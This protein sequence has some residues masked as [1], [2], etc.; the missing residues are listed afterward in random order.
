MKAPKLR[1]L[2][3]QTIVITGA[4]SGIGL[5]TARKAAAEGAKLVLA[6][7]NTEDLEELQ[8]E[9]G[10]STE[11]DHQVAVVTAD[12]SRRE[13]IQAI[14]NT[15]LTRF[16][17]IDTWINNAG[18]SI[19]GKLAEV[20]EEDSRRLFETNFWSV[21][22]GSL[23]AVKHMKEKGG[24]LINMG[25]VASDVAIPLQGMYSATKHAVKGFTD[26]LRYEL[27]KDQVPI[28]VTLIKPGGIDTPFPEHAKN[29]L[30]EQPRLP[31][32]VCVPD[33]VALAILTAA[34]RPIRDVYVGSIGPVL[35]TAQKFFP[36]LT[37]RYIEATMFKSQRRVGEPA[38]APEGSLEQPG[39]GLEERNQHPGH[40]M[41]KS[42][43]TRVKLQPW[44]RGAGYVATGV[45]ASGLILTKRRRS[46]EKQS[47]SPSEEGST[48]PDS[49]QETTS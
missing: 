47:F 18:V 39:H 11:T 30:E 31:S 41:K 48:H 29:Y 4:T 27:E 43:Y 49:I 10:Q 16:G 15:A 21:V 25:S 13:D 20:K 34:T 37:D 14:V 17:T 2:K 35:S 45:L 19:W 38:Q 3:E 40:V 26:S 5:A 42:I 36:R 28:S 1:P 9:I 12:V 22:N 24:A 23:E 6:A 8:K 44:M 32:P 7:R 33:E 46:Q